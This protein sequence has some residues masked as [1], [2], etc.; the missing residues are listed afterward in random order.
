M[1]PFNDMIDELLFGVALIVNSLLNNA[2][3]EFSETLEK[4]SAWSCKLAA[5]DF[6]R[7][8]VRS[9]ASR[10][11]SPMYDVDSRGRSLVSSIRATR[12]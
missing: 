8:G 5:L 2:K 11:L 1:L 4:R 12:I 10:N 6:I 9:D 3:M 7:T